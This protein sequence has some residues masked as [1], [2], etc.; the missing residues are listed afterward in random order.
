MTTRTRLRRAVRFVAAHLL[1]HTI[2][3]AAVAAS[4]WWFWPCWPIP[5][6]KQVVAAS[7]G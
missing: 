6:T 4:A 3:A 1:A 7:A 5:F 2:I